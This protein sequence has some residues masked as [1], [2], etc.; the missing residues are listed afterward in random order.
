MSGLAKALADSLLEITRIH[1]PTGEEREI[2]DFIETRLA[3][4]VGRVH[5]SRHGENVVVHVKR[6]EGAPRIGLV[7]HTDTVRTVHDAPPRIDGTRLYGAGASD[8]KSGLAVM[9][10]LAERSL[11]YSNPLDLTLVFYAAEEGPFVENALGPLL[12]EVEA[13]RK[14]DLAVCLEPSDNKL[15]LGCM[16]SVHATVAFTG[17]TSHSA[18]PWQGENAIVKA[19]SFLHDVGARA[20]RDVDIDGHRYREVIV[21]TT[22]SGGRGRNIVPDRFE[23]NVNFRFAPGRT[24]EDAVAEL[25]EFVAGRAEVD[26]HDLSPAGRPHASHPLVKRLLASGAREVETKQAWTDV[27]RFDQ[28]GVPAVNFGP[29]TQAQAHQRNEYTELPLLEEGYEVLRRFLNL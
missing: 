18:R 12:L 4:T 11:S 10:E 13:L 24:P 16:G 19:A 8:M 17:R 7:G 22:A 5:V 6:G 29:G 23:M 25:K 21:P 20:P 27:A 9:I 2:A 15:Q 3:R 26:A 1:S 28:I 14:L